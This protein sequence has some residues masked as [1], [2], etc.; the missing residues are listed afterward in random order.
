M[1]RMGCT[2]FRSA[3]ASTTLVAALAVVPAFAEA[4]TVA[5]VLLVI[6]DASPASV[7]V[8]DYYAKVRQLPASN[9]VRLQTAQTEAVSRLLYEATIEGPVSRWLTRHL[10][11]DQ[12]LY[13]VLTRGMPLRIDGTGGRSGT[14]ASVDS[15]LTLLYRKMTGAAVAVAG[16]LDN[17]FFLGDKP[18]SGAKR[19]TRD[20]FDLYLV[21]R[22]DGFAFDD[23]KALIDRGLAPSRDGRIV[24]D[25]KATV[26]DRGGDSWMMEAAERLRIGNDAGRVLLEP[27]TAVA[28]TTE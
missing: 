20:A 15:E 18:V 27:T 24:L 4:Q 9:I 1:G 25:Q 19:F 5:N 26:I 23:V 6:N 21:T 3:V 16:Q 28:A 11:Q 17:P 22:L 14:I 13:I 2:H 12:I 7:E 10:L 8:G